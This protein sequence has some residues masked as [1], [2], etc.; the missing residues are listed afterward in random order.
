[1]GD[2]L[3]VFEQDDEKPRCPQCRAVVEKMCRE[4]HLCKC[5]F[6]ISS[7]L[8]NCPVCG[9]PTCPCGSHNVVVLSR[10]TG[11]LAEL[12]GWNKG[13]RQEFLDRQRTVI[14]D[15]PV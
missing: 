13:K 10:V 4:D 7:G 5:T 15:L 3:I 6:E 12:G 1:M 14:A 11:Y 2:D 8:T 9:Q